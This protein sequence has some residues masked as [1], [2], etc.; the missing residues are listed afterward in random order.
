TFWRQWRDFIA[1]SIECDG[2]TSPGDLDLVKITDDVAEAVQYLV[3]FYRNYHSARFVDARL[4]IRLAHSPT[5]AELATLNSEYAD[6]V[7]R[8][9]LETIEPTQPEINDDDQLDL[10]RLA[11]RFDRHSWARLHVLIDALNELP[12]LG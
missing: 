11:F 6:I 8:G 12:S 1:G 3:R 10:A 5:D 7:L 9:A 4:V 2:Y